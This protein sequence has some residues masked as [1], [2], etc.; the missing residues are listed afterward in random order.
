[1]KTGCSVNSVVSCVGINI[2]TR[3]SLT[4]SIAEQLGMIRVIQKLKSDN[5]YSHLL[6]EKYYVDQMFDVSFTENR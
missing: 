3:L 1:M 5:H 6:E 2:T 4:E